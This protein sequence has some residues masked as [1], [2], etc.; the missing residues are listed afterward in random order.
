MKIAVDIDNVLAKS[1]ETIVGLVNKYFDKQFTIDKW[2]NWHLKE[3]ARITE[4]QQ[5]IIYS[6]FHIDRVVLNI[7]KVEYANGII[8]RLINEG[9]QISLITARPKEAYSATERWLSLNNFR[10]NILIFEKAKA[11]K[12][13]GA[14]FLIED[15]YENAIDVVEK[16]STK[17]L[18]LNKPWNLGR[19][20]HKD[21]IRFSNWQE[22]NDYLFLREAIEICQ[23]RKQ[24][25]V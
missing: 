24:A 20:K 15:S 7:P 19:P 10:H 14:D 25:A 2:T 11:K 23:K 22:I 4:E 16:T 18:L 8:A 12:M 6:M 13:D 1:A 21:I 9:N 5:E 17:V 3:C